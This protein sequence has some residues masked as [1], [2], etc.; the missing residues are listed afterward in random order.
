[1]RDGD[2]SNAA[3]EHPEDALIVF[4]V[5]RGDLS[6]EVARTR[7][8]RLPHT[9]RH[10]AA[11]LIANGFLGQDDLWPVLRSHAEW[12]I[13]RALMERPS[14]CQRELEP[15]ERLRA[16]PNVFG[17]A[18]GVEILLESVRR[19]LSPADAY[20]RLGGPEALIDEGINAELLAESA[21]SNEEMDVVR[22]APGMR[23]SQ[24]LAERGEGFAPVLY[25][26]A[27]LGI[28]RVRARSN[29]PAEPSRPEPGIDPLDVDAVRRRVEARLALVHDADYF[30]LL[31]VPAN[32]TSYDIRRAYLELRRT[33]EPSRLITAATMDLRED[34]ELIV[35][36]LDEAFEILPSEAVDPHVL[37]GVRVL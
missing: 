5:D 6:P 8:P 35:E 10:A 1:M 28:L 31:G 29:K 21:L 26:L 4:L 36:V 12:I 2:I 22:G 33:F 27:A 23:V 20:A 24:L 9:G 13:S 14:R 32:A 17:G 19:V 7:S 15:P 16:E 34:A 30:A 11:A 3:S 18:A 25:A 37:E